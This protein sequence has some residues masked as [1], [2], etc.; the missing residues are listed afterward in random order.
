MKEDMAYFKRELVNREENFNAKFSN[1][2]SAMNVG[3]MNPIGMTSKK[4][5]GG[6]KNVPFG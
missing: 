1:G 3:V 5:K 2:G 6:R 4:K